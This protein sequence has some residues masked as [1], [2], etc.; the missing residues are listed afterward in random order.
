MGRVPES[1]IPGDWGVRETETLGTFPLQPP[2]STFCPIQVAPPPPCCPWTVGHARGASQPASP[3]A[4]PDTHLSLITHLSPGP[5]RHL[6]SSQWER[7]Q[8]PQTSGP[9]EAPQAAQGPG[10]I[11]RQTLSTTCHCLKFHHSQGPPRLQD[12]RAPPS[13]SRADTWV[14][15]SHTHK[16]RHTDPHM[17][18][19][20]QAMARKARGEDG[21][22][23]RNS[24]SPCWGSACPSGIV[25]APLA[26][27]STPPTPEGARLSGR[28][29]ARLTL[30]PL[31]LPPARGDLV[32][33]HLLGGRD[34]T[35]GAAE[36]RDRAK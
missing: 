20:T 3:L 24:I 13:P 28:E 30:R 27:G 12:K 10:L 36:W 22:R 33:G 29:R 34:A 14:Q 11:P 25:G 19:Q 5:P 26:A 35:L 9:S 2:P 16:H 18:T 23:T 4:S 8:G 1:L 17:S 7:L 6:P 31:P 15:A 32:G 21:A